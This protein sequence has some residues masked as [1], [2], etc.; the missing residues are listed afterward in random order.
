MAGAKKPRGRPSDFTQE[1]ADKICELVIE[2]DY[3]LEQF[4]GK[5]GLP[6]ARTE[7]RWLASNESF[8]QQYARAKVAQGHVQADRGL[9]DALQ[10]TDAQLG[11]LKWD[12]RRWAASKLAPKQ[13]GDKTTTEHTGK[14]GGPIETHVLPADLAAL[15]REKRDAVRNALKAAMKG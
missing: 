8:R 7:F 14:D 3:G 6:S 11:R 9:R 10:A 12:A 5:D 4:C 2:S 15:P 1:I 13:Y